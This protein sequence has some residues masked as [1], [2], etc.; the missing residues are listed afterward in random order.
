MQSPSNLSSPEAPKT[1]E[2]ES[3][4]FHGLVQRLVGKEKEVLRLQAEVA[5]LNKSGTSQ[6]REAVSSLLFSRRTSSTDRF[7]LSLG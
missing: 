3:P 5:R 7:V 4:N 2:K 1:A 6:P